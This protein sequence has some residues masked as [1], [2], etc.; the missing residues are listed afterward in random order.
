MVFALAQ[1]Q[2]G[3]LPLGTFHSLDQLDQTAAGIRAGRGS[4]PEQDYGRHHCASA[5]TREMLEQDLECGTDGGREQDVPFLQRERRQDHEQHVDAD[6]EP[7]HAAGARA[8]RQGCP[9]QEKGHRHVKQP[10]RER[11]ERRDRSEAATRPE[12]RD[13][14]RPVDR[15]QAEITS[16]G[17]QS[18]EPP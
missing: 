18:Q 3:T 5:D 9:L 1:P 12:H 7:G 4:Q 13:G 8:G 10:N 16:P 11:R 6:G 17:G 14:E 15:E 2:L